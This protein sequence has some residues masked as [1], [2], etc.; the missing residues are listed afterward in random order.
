[1]AATPSTT[2]PLSGP[3]AG[4][5]PLDLCDDTAPAAA[6]PLSLFGTLPLLESDGTDAPPPSAPETGGMSLGLMAPTEDKMLHGDKIASDDAWIGI[7]DGWDDGWTGDDIGGGDDIVIDDGFADA[8]FWWYAAGDLNGDGIGDL[9]AE[10]WAYTGEDYSTSTY[11]L[12]GSGDGGEPAGDPAETADGKGF[13]LAAPAG[14]SLWAAAAGDLNGDGRDDLLVTTYGDD[15]TTSAHLVFGQADGWSGTVDVT[16]GYTFAFD[17]PAGMDSSWVSAAGDV[18][19]DGIADIMVDVSGSDAEGNYTGTSYVIFGSAAGFPAAI[20]LA[21][22]D[23][24]LGRE[25]DWYAEDGTIAVDGG[26]CV[27][28]PVDAAI[29]PLLA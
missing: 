14:R 29:E 18:N 8:G 9:A 3:L 12:F 13:V 1:M 22:L 20:D 15:G 25:F 17:L 5:A 10:T 19:D 2:S 11:V 24:A 16:A 23:P 21:A 4:V 6:D 7:D 27:L 26:P 28:Y